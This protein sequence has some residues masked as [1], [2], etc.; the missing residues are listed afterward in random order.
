MLPYDFALWALLFLHVFVAVISLVPDD[1]LN[2]DK[3]D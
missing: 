2:N 1:K 3:E